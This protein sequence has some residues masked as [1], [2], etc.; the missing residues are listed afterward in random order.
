ME[1]L[2]FLYLNF[3]TPVFRRVVLWYGDVCPSVRPTVRV[4]VRQSQFSTL[5]SFMLWRIEMKFGMPLSCY[6]HSI[7]FECRQFPSS[8]IGVMPLLE[9]I[10]YW[11]YTVF[12][13]FLQHALT[14]CAEILHMTLFYCTTDQVWVSLISV[15]FRRSYAPFGT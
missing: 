11:K 5:F 9:L 2:Y 1:L 14:Y 15:R 10:K 12:R 13:S 3:Y 7:K 4:S 6:E 8:F